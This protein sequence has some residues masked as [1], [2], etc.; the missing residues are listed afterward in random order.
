LQPLGLSHCTYCW[1]D[2]GLLSR[3]WVGESFSETI[4]LLLDSLDLWLPLGNIIDL[5]ADFM[6]LIAS[7]KMMLLINSVSI[8]WHKF[9][10]QFGD[11][12]F[13]SIC[14]EKY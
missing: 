9:S 5:I 4:G 14:W 8:V 10:T 13:V 1:V 11:E 2:W 3:L 6:A 7:L 12:G